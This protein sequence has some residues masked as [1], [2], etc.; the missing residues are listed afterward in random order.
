MIVQMLGRKWK[1]EVSTHFGGVLVGIQ[2]DEEM[3]DILGQSDHCVNAGGCQVF[4]PGGNRQRKVFSAAQIIAVIRVYDQ[5]RDVI[6]YA[7]KR[8]FASL[9]LFSG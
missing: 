7:N 5:A 3:S 4:S 9:Q 8:A 2:P 1:R 6:G